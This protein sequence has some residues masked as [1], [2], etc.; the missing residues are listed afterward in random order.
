[1]N[2]LNLNTESKETE[3]F[4]LSNRPFQHAKESGKILCCECFKNDGQ[5]NFVN[6][7][8]GMKQ[9]FRIMH[10]SKDLDNLILAECK[11]LFQHAHCEETASV[12]QQLGSLRLRIQTVSL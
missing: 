4:S 10:N 5:H 9:H 11:R 1:M 8:S 2:D 3:I 7:D 6:E 12:I